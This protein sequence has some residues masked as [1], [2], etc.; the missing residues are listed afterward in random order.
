VVF[1][2][3]LATMLAG[4]SLSPEFG[5]HA[6]TPASEI[7]FWLKFGECPMVTYTVPELVPILKLKERAIRNLL[8]SGKLPARRINRQWIVSEHS[9]RAFLGEKRRQE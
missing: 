3:I 1:L 4:V 8:A 9:L 2:D 6:E 7:I 5:S